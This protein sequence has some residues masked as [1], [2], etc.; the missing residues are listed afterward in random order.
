MLSFLQHSKSSSVT[1]IAHV[2]LISCLVFHLTF[3]TEEIATAIA[4]TF[5]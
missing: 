5:Q 2:H 1:L 4:I 3:Y